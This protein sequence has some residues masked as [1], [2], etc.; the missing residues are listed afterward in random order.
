MAKAKDQLLKLEERRTLDKLL[1]GYED[2]DFFFYLRLKKQLEDGILFNFYSYESDEELLQNP[3]QMINHVIMACFPVWNQGHKLIG[4]E[5][6]VT[7]LFSGDTYE[8][9]YLDRKVKGKFL[10]DKTFR[11]DQRIFDEHKTSWEPVALGEEEGEP[12]YY[13][14]RGF[15]ARIKLVETGNSRDSYEEVFMQNRYER[16]KLYQETL[17]DNIGA[18]L[19]QFTKVQSL[20]PD[21]E[22]VVKKI[23]KYYG[24]EVSSYE[25]IFKIR[26]SNLLWDGNLKD[27]AY[28]RIFAEQILE[29]H[30]LLNKELSV[31]ENRLDKLL[32]EERQY[33]MDNPCE[34]RK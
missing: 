15:T 27:L 29:N 32:Y 19:I 22:H 25:D 17:K 30:N 24:I 12:E 1:N 33:L 8:V 23:A 18:A 34:G 4:I 7:F 31:L 20:L 5:P 11:S 6:S 26:K 13:Q 21:K 28:I 14:T 16:L 10:L 2:S 9:S 3:R